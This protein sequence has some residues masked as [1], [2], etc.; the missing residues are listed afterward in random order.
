MH[1]YEARMARFVDK[2]MHSFSRC[3]V[4]L[5]DPVTDSQ[6]HLIVPNKRT[7]SAVAFS[8]DG[9]YFASGE[10]SQLSQVWLVSS[11]LYPYSTVTLVLRNI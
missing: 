3:V 10:V 5:L 4:V 11:G 2:F 8:N 1:F 9:R 6:Q 7:L